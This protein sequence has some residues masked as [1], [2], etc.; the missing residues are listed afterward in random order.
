MPHK[1]FISYRR[2]DAGANALGISQYLEKEFGRKSVFIDV[3]M[4]AGAKF[5]AVLEER[6]TEQIRIRAVSM[7]N[8]FPV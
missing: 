3:D 5:P 6:L 2:E 4:R 1:I 8:P 7:Q